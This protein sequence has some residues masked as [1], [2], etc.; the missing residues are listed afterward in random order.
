MLQNCSNQNNVEQAQRQTL[1]Q[2]NRIESP[3]INPHIYHQL[4]YSTGARNIQLEKDSVYVK[5]YWK[6]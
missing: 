4:T 3:E 5:W 1:D 2:Q 6:S